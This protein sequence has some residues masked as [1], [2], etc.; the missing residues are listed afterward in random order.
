MQVVLPT[1][2]P[3]VHPLLGLLDDGVA[4]GFPLQV[5]GDCGSQKPEGCSL[6]MYHGNSGNKQNVQGRLNVSYAVSNNV[7]GSL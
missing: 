5:P 3:E 7:I 4:V 6:R 2:A 1:L